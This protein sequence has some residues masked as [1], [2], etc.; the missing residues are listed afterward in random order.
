MAGIIAVAGHTILSCDINTAHFCAATFNETVRHKRLAQHCLRVPNQP[1]TCSHC[2]HR[3]P[4]VQRIHQTATASQLQQTAQCASV[5]GTRAAA[6]HLLSRGPTNYKA[7]A[8]LPGCQAAERLIG[9]AHELGAYA[10]SLVE[11]QP[12]C[13]HDQAAQQVEAGCTTVMCCCYSSQTRPRQGCSA[14]CMHHKR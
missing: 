12:Y 7:V 13:Q 8:R 9:S 3:P 2:P 4:G 6:R 10:T 1:G 5:A 11:S 14:G